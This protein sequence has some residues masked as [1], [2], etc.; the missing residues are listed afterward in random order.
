VLK[1]T[2]ALV[3]T[4]ALVAFSHPTHAQEVPGCGTLANAYGPFDYR[5]YGTRQRYLPIVESYHFTTEVRTLQSGKSST[6]A[7]DL[8]YTLRAFPNHPAALDAVG[9]YALRGGKFPVDGISADCFYQRALAF[10][11]DDPAVRVTY[12]NYLFKRHKKDEAREQYEEALRLAPE[13]I[14]ISYNAGLFFLDIGELERAKALAKF[15][16]DRDYPLPGLKNKIAL[17]EAHKPKN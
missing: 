5:E 14:E 9:R 1:V 3:L 12:A 4:C 16:Y 13:S 6:L 7:G 10:A 8:D 15:A 17:A 11:P 2:A